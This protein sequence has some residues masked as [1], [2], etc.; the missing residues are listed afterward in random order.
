L[1]ERKK[2]KTRAGN[3]TGHCFLFLLFL[4]SRNERGKLWKQWDFDYFWRWIMKA[5][6]D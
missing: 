5:M 2:K 4:S 1:K 6:A 3:E